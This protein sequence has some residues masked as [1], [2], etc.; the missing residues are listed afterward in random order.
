MLAVL[1]S[2]LTLVLLGGAFGFLF[3]RLLRLGSLV[4]VGTRGDERLTDR[5]RRPGGQGRR[6]GLR[7][8]E[9]PGGPLGG[10]LARHLPLRLPRARHRPPRGRARGPDR[11]PE[12]VRRAS[13]HLRA[14]TAGGARRG[15]SPEPGPARRRSC[16]WPRRSRS[17]GACPAASRACCRAR[18]TGRSS[19][20]S[21]SRSTSPS[22]SSW[23][24]ARGS[25]RRPGGPRPVAAQPFSS[26]VAAALALP[27]SASRPSA[28]PPTGRTS[29]SSSASP[30][31]IPISKH[32][33]LVFAAPNIYFFRRKRYGLPPAL[34]FEKTEK[35]GIDRVQELP[36]KSL[37]DTFACTE[38]GRCNVVCPAHETGKPLQPM[39]VLHDIKLNLRYRNARGPDGGAR[40]H[41][42]AG[43]REGAGGPG[44]RTHGAARLHGSRSIPLSPGSCA[45]TGPTSRSTA[46]S[47]STRSGRARPARPASRPVRCSSTPFPAP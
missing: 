44:L 30:C 18:A 31:Y 36:W 8:P 38:C 17:A 7:T 25:G 41:R 3:T 35:F 11:L 21:S 46:R 43:A 20:G 39:K 26:R 47:T 28:P 2:L 13:L 19:S 12:G 27:T 4:N 16:C 9:G 34:D 14:D 32:M 22:S 1:Q 42:S 37:L 15:L 24:R 6:D 23:D 5:P 40:P 29:W 33:H 10:R 45:R